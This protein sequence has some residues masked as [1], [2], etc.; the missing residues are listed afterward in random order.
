MSEERSFNNVSHISISKT[1]KGYIVRI[2]RKEVL[3]YSK[4][5]NFEWRI[6]DGVM[7]SFSHMYFG[8]EGGPNNTFGFNI[9]FCAPCDIRI[10][11]PDARC[12]IHIEKT[13]SA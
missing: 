3:E 12:Y 5:T 9:T 6:S 1:S 7:P 8:E 11:N 13:R 2:D 4:A 10:S